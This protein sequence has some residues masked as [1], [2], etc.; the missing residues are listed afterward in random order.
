M[1]VVAVTS[2]LAAAIHIL[3]AFC[4][5]EVRNWRVYCSDFPAIEKATI[6]IVIGILR[7]LFITILNIYVPN[8]VVSQVVHHNHVLDF[9][10]LA[11]LFKHFLKERLKSV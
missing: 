6:N 9:T 7:V 5:Y 11:H 3:L 8:D 10:I 4:V 1:H 2:S